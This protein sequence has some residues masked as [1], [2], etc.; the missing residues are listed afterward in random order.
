MKFSEIVGLTSAEDKKREFFNLI[1]RRNLGA[2]VNALNVVMPNEDMNEWKIKD[3]VFALSPGT[4]GGKT[5]TKKDSELHGLGPGATMSKPVLIEQDAVID[6]LTIAIRQQDGTGSMLSDPLITVKATAKVMIRNCTF[7][8]RD[9]S[10]AAHI[11]IESGGK[12]VV[13]GCVFKGAATSSTP[14]VNHPVGAATDVQVAYCY[15]RTGNTL[16]SAADVTL[17]GNI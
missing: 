3:N 13:I 10:E 4:H 17:T 11:H 14:V 8:Q 16:G 2:T 15:N 7:E 1:A 5:L 9:S 6:G 12:A